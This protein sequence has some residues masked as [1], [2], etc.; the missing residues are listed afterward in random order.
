MLRAAHRPHWD[1]GFSLRKLHTSLRWR[2]ICINNG[3]PTDEQLQAEDLTD[4]HRPILHP[5]TMTATDQLEHEL[6]FANIISKHFGIPAEAIMVEAQ[7]CSIECCTMVGS[8]NNLVYM[9]NLA[10]PVEK[11]LLHK[12]GDPKPFTHSIPAGVTQ[13]VA[14]IPRPER[15]LEDSVRIRNQVASQALARNALAG[16]DPLPVPRVY[17]WDDTAP[18][19]IIEE[20]KS[21]E[22]LTNEEW[23][24]LDDNSVRM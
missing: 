21:G 6:F 16:V 3:A 1:D 20:F 7:A 17:D 5:I 4:R 9:I 19:Y 10:G 12:G 8:G 11:E 14:R 15:G 23:R 18:G 13:F 24:A 2:C 22:V